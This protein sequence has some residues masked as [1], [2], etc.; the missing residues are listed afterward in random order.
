MWKHRNRMDEDDDL[1]A[2]DP[3]FD[4]EESPRKSFWQKMFG[5]KEPEYEDGERDDI[6]S[7]YDDDPP[8]RKP[9]GRLILSGVFAVA[10]A[11]I[12]IILCFSSLFRSDAGTLYTALRNSG[13]DLRTYMEDTSPLF[14][15]ADQMAQLLNDGDF[16]LSLDIDNAGEGFIV[17][18]DYSRDKK[19]MSGVLRWNNSLDIAFSADETEMRLSAPAL[20]DDVYGFRFDDFN[21]RNQELSEWLEKLPVNITLP[22]TDLDFFSPVKLDKLLKD[23]AAESWTAF[24]ESL[25][26]EK[27]TSRDV[28]LG[29]HSEY[30][31]IYQ[32]S[33][34]PA[35]ADALV[36][37]LSG[38]LTAI[39]VGILTLL[40]DLEP[41]CRL[42]VNK[43]KRVIGGDCSVLGKKYTVLMSGEDH[44]WDEISLEILSAGEPAR[45]LTGGIEVSERSIG[46][47]VCDDTGAFLTADY[48]NGTGAFR[49]CTPEATLFEGALAMTGKSVNLELG[50]QAAPV[51]RLE[52]SPLTKRPVVDT[53]KYVDIPGMSLNE[54]NRLWME[55]QNSLRD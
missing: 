20:A 52:V 37:D 47:Q 54:L 14:T 23:R 4:E 38:P 12:V 55:Y 48:D 36:K 3:V 11:A 35:A 19:L 13:N 42:F 21:S 6:I 8:R 53:G 10:A 46:L 28:Q 49:I 43:D 40:P 17:D 30:C 7:D 45:Y 27:F 22:D 34:D 24:K 31:T 50:S 1:Y 25:T 9:A 32:V 51:L 15:S 5:S 2:D 26:I 39:P 33:W 44:F 29:E 41:D 16:R 18:M